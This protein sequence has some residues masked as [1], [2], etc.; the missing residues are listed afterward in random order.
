MDRRRGGELER[1][2]R[3]LVVVDATMDVEAAL[4]LEEVSGRLDLALEGAVE[5]FEAAVL[6]RCGRGDALEH[7]AQPQEPDA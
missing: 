3:S 7:D 2:V 4:L 1:R 6:Q 5:A